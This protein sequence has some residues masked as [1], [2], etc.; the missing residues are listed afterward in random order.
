MAIPIGLALLFLMA[1]APA[2]PWRG[3]ERGRV[4][5]AA[6]SCPPAIGGLTMLVRCCS[7][8]RGLAEVLAYGLGAFATA[9]IVRQFYLGRGRKPRAAGIVHGRTGP[10]DASNPRLYG[11]LVV[12]L[13]CGDDRGGARGVVG[14]RRQPRGAPGEGAVGR[15]GR[16]HAHLPRLV[17]D[18]LR[19][20]RTRP[21]PASGS[22]R[23][24]TTWASTRRA[25]P[26]SRTAATASVPRRCERAWSTT[27]T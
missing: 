21:M 17:R 23:A 14:L 4:A 18:V 7:A 8:R 16:L 9:G 11:G 15:G 6:C 19:G 1:V 20:E 22:P 2:L 10:G 3:D 12:H 27:C 25:S 5:Q 24:I 13:G 26:R